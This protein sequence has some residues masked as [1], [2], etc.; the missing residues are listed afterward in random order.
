MNL[1]EILTKIKSID[2]QTKGW[3]DSIFSGA[4]H[5]RF[6]G[7]GIH[8]SDVRHYDYGDDVRRI[9][10]RVTA[11]LNEPYIKEFEEERDL[12]VMLAIDMSQSQYY[13]SGDTSKLDQVLEAAAILGF[14]AAANGDQVGL[15]LFTNQVETFIP[16]KSGKRH[17]Y[18]VLSQILNHQ[19]ASNHT[20]IR[21]CCA[22][23]AN[24]LKRRS[25]CFILSDFIADNYDTEFKQLSQRHDV[26]PIIVQDPTELTIP[27]G[28]SV[29][30]RDS[31]TGEVVLCDTNNP[32]TQAA[33]ASILSSQHQRRDQ[34]FNH[35]GVT[36]LFCGTNDSMIIKLQQ[37]FK[38]RPR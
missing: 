14:S 25:V 36:P 18:G 10:W 30:L 6:K 13:Q 32:T 8:F 24:S 22:T 1:S 11:K 23:L 33:M 4:Y 5:S 34:L 35:V 2:I 38:S 29:A 26:I 28:G 37:Y 21:Q 27:S 20:S 12:T 17:M 15:A 16:P 7:Q 19:P 3:V 9:D 31:E